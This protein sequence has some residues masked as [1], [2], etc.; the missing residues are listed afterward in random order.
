MAASHIPVIECVRK[1]IVTLDWV[2][3]VGDALILNFP[4]K[5]FTGCSQFYYVHTYIVQLVI[6]PRHTYV[7][8]LL[9]SIARF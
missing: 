7:S 3:G 5:C 4:H 2:G 8:H 9:A 6:N 1:W